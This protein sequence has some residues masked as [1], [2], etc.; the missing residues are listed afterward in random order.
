MDIWQACIGSVHL[1]HACIGFSSRLCVVLTSIRCSGRPSGTACLHC[2]FTCKLPVEMAVCT[3]I[4]SGPAPVGLSPILGRPT[5]ANSRVFIWVE[6]RV[7][8]GRYTKTRRY[9]ALH[10]GV[11]SLHFQHLCG[12]SSRLYREFHY[13]HRIC[14][15]ASAQ[16]LYRKAAWDCLCR[17]P[18]AMRAS[19]QRT[20]SCGCI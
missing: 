1:R 15:L 7:R 18:S 3:A 20:T 14:L 2:M 11:C 17:N 16:T 8:L 13:A 19:T 5:N 4:S 10:F 12:A 6:P 9:V